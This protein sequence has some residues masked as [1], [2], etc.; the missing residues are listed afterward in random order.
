MSETRCPYTRGNAR[1]V[2]GPNHPITY[3]HLDDDTNA[4]DGMDATIADQFTTIADDLTG[5]EDGLAAQ[6]RRQAA[7]LRELEP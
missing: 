3:H 1:C 6:F 5:I 7:R 4:R 2:F